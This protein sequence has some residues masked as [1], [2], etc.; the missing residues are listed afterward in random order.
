MPRKPNQK[1][2]SYIV[3]TIKEV[4]YE[5]GSKVSTLVRCNSSSDDQDVIKELDSISKDLDEKYKTKS[6]FID[7]ILGKIDDS[8]EYFQN[9]KTLITKTNNLKIRGVHNSE[10]LKLQLLYKTLAK[11]F[12]VNQQ[13]YSLSFKCISIIIQSISYD[14]N[15]N[16]MLNYSYFDELLDAKALLLESIKKDLDLNKQNEYTDKAIEISKEKEESNEKL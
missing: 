11:Q 1:T 9:Y 12:I 8:L 10:L 4:S 7:V 14:L 16:L 13:S 15:F 5:N 3:D 6:E 2:M